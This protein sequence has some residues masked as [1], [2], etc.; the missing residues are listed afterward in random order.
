MTRRALDIAVSGLALVFAAPLLLLGALSVR[1]SSPGPILYRAKRVGR[2]GVLFEMFKLRTMHARDAP[3]A[4]ITAGRDPRIF[5]AGRLLRLLKIDELPQLVNVLRGDMA[6]VGPRPE[7]PGI[8]ERAY[9]SWM[10]ET[11]EVRPGVTS[12]GSLHYYAASERDVDTADPETD[13]VA[14]FLAPKLAIDRA[15]MDRAGVGSD[16]AIG[17]R[18]AAAVLGRIVGWTID[19]PRRD[20]RV[21]AAWLDAPIATTRILLTHRYYPPDGS[22]YGAILEGIAAALVRQGCE[23]H[24]LAAMPTYRETDERPPLIEDAAG[25]RILRVPMLRER[26]GMLKAKWVNAA[27]YGICA[28]LR[29]VRLRPDIAVAATFPPVIAAAAVSL[30]ARMTGARFVYHVQDVH[31]EISQVVDGADGPAIAALKMV[32]SATL[33]RADRII[34]LSEDMAHTLRARTSGVALPITVAPNPALQAAPEPPPPGLQA[35]PGLRRILFAGNLGRF[36]DLHVLAEGVV[37]ALYGR[38]DCELC[39]LGDGTERSALEERW[40]AHPNVRFLPFLPFAQAQGVIAGAEVG[41]ASLQLGL[42][43]LAYPSKI[44]TYHALGLRVFA[45]VDPQSQIAR[46][47]R[48]VGGAVPDQRTPTEIAATL[49]ALLDAPRCGRAVCSGGSATARLARVI[50]DAG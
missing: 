19:A 10:R 38:A 40:S 48:A 16:L 47:I 9:V 34:T 31:P 41:L 6:L 8:V 20:R 24:V 22:P 27:L 30:A 43:A 28:A 13:Y 45:L 11:L 35:G 5:P 49:G 25:H 37:G 15:Y 32:D 7:D 1:L 18:T 26:G 17:V 12:P 42:E 3:D 29:V 46:D 21:A 39:F 50:A 23:V 33:R 4:V 36:Q 14:R 2:G 44:A